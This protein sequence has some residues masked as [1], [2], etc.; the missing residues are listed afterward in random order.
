[1]EK[2]YYQVDEFLTVFGTDKNFSHSEFFEIT[3]SI[4]TAREK[5]TKW[6]NSRL[7]GLAL[8]KTFY[9]AELIEPNTKDN[10]IGSAAFSIDF[11]LVHEYYENGKKY[12]D[13]YCFTD[14]S[15]QEAI[16]LENYLMNQQIF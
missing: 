5:A 11:Y 7:D 13:S 3:S 12:Q 4:E 9:D 6:Y 2:Y 8:K 10:I 16:E 1:M 14:D 15:K